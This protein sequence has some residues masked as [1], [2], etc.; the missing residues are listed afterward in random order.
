MFDPIPAS[1]TPVLASLLPLNLQHHLNSGE[2]FVCLCQPY[3]AAARAEGGIL[4]SMYLAVM[5]SGRS[6]LYGISWDMLPGRQ[7]CF[8]GVFE[9]QPEGHMLLVTLSYG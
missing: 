1:L 7:P 6:D 9:Q 8:S 4:S 5:R 3:T 2:A